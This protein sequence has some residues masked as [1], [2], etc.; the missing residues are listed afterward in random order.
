MTA[1]WPIQV[2]PTGAFV[3]AGTTRRQQI[4]TA[5]ALQLQTIL[6]SNGYTTDLGAHVYE[7]DT[8]P[9]DPGTEL[10]RLEYRDAEESAGYIAVG[11]HYHKMPVEIRIICVQPTPLA[12]I[13]QMIA[14][15]TVAIGLDFTFGG[16]AIDTNLDDVWTTD[17]G[18]AADVA[19]GAS[20]KMVVEFLTEPWNPYQ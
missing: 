17:K 13:R 11:E 18:Q 5:M 1:F 6:V 20:G 8:T 7:W 2:W 12:V 16:L 10:L 9:V 3:P 4:L 19:T 15:V 14:D